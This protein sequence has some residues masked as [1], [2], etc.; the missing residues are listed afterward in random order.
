MGG[1]GAEF[2]NCKKETIGAP[3]NPHETDS[4]KADLG[5]LASDNA[6]RW[7]LGDCRMSYGA[8]VIR[9][10]GSGF[11]VGLV[12]TEHTWNRDIW[13]LIIKLRG[14]DGTIRQEIGPL[15]G[16]DMHDDHQWQRW[17]ADFQYNPAIF[18]EVTTVAVDGCC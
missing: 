2:G 6:H 1:I 11:F 10:N 5:Y 4:K 12:K 14:P 17:Q 9:P 16:P 13:H 15:N 18:G 7:E 3:F 8:V